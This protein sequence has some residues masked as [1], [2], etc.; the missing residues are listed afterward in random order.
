MCLSRGGPPRAIAR[1]SA[2]PISDKQAVC[3][4][5][6][7]VLIQRIAIAQRASGTQR[8]QEIQLVLASCAQTVALAR[9]CSRVRE[10]PI[11]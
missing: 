9:Q 4:Q 3:Q 1:I 10:Q 5:F 7:A 2:V 6:V 8:T 11:E